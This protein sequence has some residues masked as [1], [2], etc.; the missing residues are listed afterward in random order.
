MGWKKICLLIFALCV[1]LSSSS[2]EGIMVEGYFSGT[3]DV[4]NDPD[5]RLPNS[6]S[7]FSGSFTYDSEAIPVHYPD[8]DAYYGKSFKLS[9]GPNE[10]IQI[11]PVIW[12]A[13]DLFN[14]DGI[15]F[16]NHIGVY[17]VIVGAY[18]QTESVFNDRSLPTSIDNSD[19][20]FRFLQMFIF[21]EPSDP[22]FISG[23]VTNF[24]A[25]PVP[26]PTTMLLLGSGLIGLAGYGRKRF[27]KK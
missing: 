10:L 16:N 1:F 8:A 14:A 6:G 9:L 18:D 4:F 23:T 20:D 22:F 17:G 25:S 19:F 27:F 7:F 15:T 12:I 11:N 26:E 5:N 13:N 24:S 2:A 3:L 21:G